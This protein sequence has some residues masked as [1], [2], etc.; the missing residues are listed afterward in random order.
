MAK[1]ALL[2]DESRGVRTTSR[3]FP[4]A[5]SPRPRTPARIRSGCGSGRRGTRKWA[6]T[7]LAKYAPNGPEISYENLA[8]PVLE[9]EPRWYA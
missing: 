8:T 5:P 9:P 6:K 4:A 2:R 7:T 3:D 1:G